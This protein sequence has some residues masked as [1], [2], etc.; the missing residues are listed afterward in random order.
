MES[1][2]TVP[3]RFSSGLPVLRQA[4]VAMQES[5]RGFGAGLPQCEGDTLEDLNIV[6]NRAMIEESWHWHNTQ[7]WHLE[8]KQP[9]AAAPK[10]GY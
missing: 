5:W 9:M 3:Q 1:N 10:D 2:P 4:W 8:G 7:S 6:G